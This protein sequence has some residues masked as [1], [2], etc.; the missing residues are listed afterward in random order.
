MFKVFFT[1]M[2]C[3]LLVSLQG[4]SQRA[5]PSSDPGY[6]YHAPQTYNASFQ[7]LYLYLSSTFLVV[8]KEGQVSLDSCMIVASR[9]MGVSRFAVLGEGMED[10][11][12]AAQSKWIDQQDPAKGIRLLSEAVGTKHLQLEI[13]LGAYY[14][15]QPHP[16]NRYKDSVEY[17]LN[18]ALDESRT[19]KQPAL[20]RQAL[21]LLVK[22]YADGNDEKANTVC[23]MLMAQCQQAGDKGTVARV[24]AYRSKYTPPLP[25]TIARKIDDA[26][27]A[28]AIFDSTGNKAGE[29]DALTD[30]GYLQLILGQAQPAYDNHLKALKLCEDIRFPYTQYNT[31]ALITTTEFLGKFGEPLRYA[32][33]TMRAAQDT[34]DSVA[35]AYFDTNLAQLFNW[36]GRYKEAT[37]WARKSVNRFVADR[38]SS[39]YLILYIVVVAMEQEGHAREALD[40]VLDV[41]K[42]VGPP[43][44][45]SDE[46]AYHLVLSECYTEREMFAEAE[47][48]IKKMDELET[49]AT[50]IRGPMR[51]SAVDG[52]Y[53]YLFMKQRQYRKAMSFFEK[54]LKTPALMD[55]FMMSNMEA[56]RQMVFIDSILG[57]HIAAERHYR[58]YAQLLDS[59]FQAANVRQAEE[60]QVVYQMQEKEGQ[61]SLLTQQSKLEKA[62]L[63]KA[64]IERDFTVAGIFAVLIIAILLYR[65]SRLRKK[66]NMLIT[67]KNDQ[68][69]QL[70]ADKEWLLKEVHHRVKNNL[71]IIISLLD[72]QS[73]YID[74]EAA[75]MAIE[76]NMRRV[77]AMA[78]IH[79]KLYEFDENTSISMPEYIHE[80]VDY[81]RDSFDTGSRIIFEQTCE[82]IALDISQVIPIGLIINESIVNAIKYAFP[83]NRKGIVRIS[84]YKVGMDHLVLEISDNGI[85]L[86]AGFNTQAH[87]SLGLDLMQG[88]TRQMNGTFSYES[89]NGLHISIRFAITSHPTFH[90]SLM[91]Y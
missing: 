41:V 47:M 52:Q 50:V 12:L 10:P 84:F 5:V 70:V 65:Q 31:Q 66:N 79:Q 75:L 45:L 88:L 7:R 16:Y 32:Y 81:A 34:R 35:W 14:A 4:M 74:N 71:Q 64:A 76:D 23:Q 49:S 43:S 17:F 22:L 90:K 24:L 53:A 15:F 56:Y 38:N 13:L 67:R 62:N 39:V 29:I 19:L 60:L 28:A 33:Q 26:Q 73:E 51:R 30:L 3:G 42:K 59:N 77:H 40:Y 6:V 72:S 87:S 82:P 46:F 89:K 8:A 9:S 11:S 20:G 58:R 2:L 27:Q 86:P 48:H 18:R 83:N 78:L 68:L 55:A 36:E 44:T 25:T 85:G 57:D 63:A 54:R 37:E 1:G 91:T 80:L 21:A 61:I 69:Q